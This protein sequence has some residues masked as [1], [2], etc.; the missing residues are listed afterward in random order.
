MIVVASYILVIA[1]QCLRDM[2]DIDLTCN[3]VS[4]GCFMLVNMQCVVLK[5]P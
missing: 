3:I 1:A 2:C 4:C 5:T